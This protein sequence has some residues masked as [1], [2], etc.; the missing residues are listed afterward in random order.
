MLSFQ[1]LRLLVQTIEHRV[2]VFESVERVVKYF[3]AL[4]CL[5][6]NEAPSALI[7]S[8]VYLLV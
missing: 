6:N 1:F 3:G 7:K 2:Q 8:A 5:K 4:G